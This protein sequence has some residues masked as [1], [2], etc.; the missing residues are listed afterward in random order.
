MSTP[1]TKQTP[2]ASDPLV[3]SL[4][5]G[6]YEIT[7]LLG[8]GDFGRV[9]KARQTQI[10]RT[11]AVKTLKPEL[12]RD[13]FDAE[14]F[15]K[16]SE[17]ILSLS[18]P[19]IVAVYETGMT[20]GAEPYFVMDL[21]NGET[22]SDLIHAESPLEPS[23]AAAIVI[24]I[25]DALAHAHDA[26]V[27]HGDLKPSNA[28]VSESEAQNDLV[29]LVDFDIGKFV[30]RPEEDL[31]GQTLRNN[32]LDSSHYMSPE[33]CR[34]EK[35]DPRSDVYSLGCVLREMLVG[36]PP[37]GGETPE[38]TINSHINEPAE[39]F[40][41]LLE[42]TPLASELEFIALKALRKDPDF[43][44]QSAS[45]ML[46]DLQSAVKG[47]S[48]RGDQPQSLAH[49]KPLSQAVLMQV[50]LSVVLLCTL[51]GVVV[52]VTHVAR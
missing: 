5:S 24:Q 34:N 49:R 40:F 36:H 4:L 26:G 12:M 22:L 50:I 52:L 48:V 27:L 20:P 19:N 28:I 16:S 39:P 23:R 44:Y 45:A 21:L 18:H 35:L 47:I 13:S 15:V 9:Y 30:R 25:A 3:G 29:K 8:E 11:L 17:P 42:N 14:A 46:A 38:A 1:E 41:H 7:S 10:N 43:R 51:A 33:R 6:R 2:T 31:S 37:F 32:L